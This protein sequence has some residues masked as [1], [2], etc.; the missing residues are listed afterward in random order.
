MQQSITWV[1]L[2]DIHYSLELKDL[3]ERVM[4]RLEV[5]LAKVLEQH[6]LRPDL[7]F[8]TGDLAH[9]KLDKHKGEQFADQFSRAG[10]LIERLKTKLSL[11]TDRIFVVPGNHDVDRGCVF[12]DHRNWLDEA[13]PDKIHRLIDRADGQWKHYASRLSTFRDFVTSHRLGHSSLDPDR[14]VAADTVDVGPTK[15]GIASFNTAWSCCRDSKDEKGQLWMG[16]EWQLAFAED[17]LK[18]CQLRIALLHHPSNWLREAEDHP[19]KRA[20]ERQ[21]HYV[22][23]GHEHNNWLERAQ[24]GATRISAAACF[25]PSTQDNGY[26]IARCV[27]DKRLELWFRRF[28]QAGDGFTSRPIHGLT[29]DSG[30]FDSEMHDRRPA[31]KV[32]VPRPTIAPAP[33][34]P[35][36]RD[37]SGAWSTT[38]A[39]D[40]PKGKRRR[41]ITDFIDLRLEDGGFFGENRD[42]VRHEY[43]VEGRVIAGN[44]FVGVWRSR[45][46]G[47]VYAGCFLMSIDVEGRIMKGRWLGIGES[48]S[49]LDGGR[50]EWQRTDDGKKPLRVIVKP[51]TKSITTG[52]GKAPARPRR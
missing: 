26:S 21:Y 20:L 30:Y 23:H 33:L 38:Y 24:H 37:L 5:D 32:V 42:N 40:N 44:W 43:R 25:D 7:L 12:E 13:T 51:A 19:L 18:A 45:K 15:I 3:R 9:G 29:D 31:P 39:F 4:A 2:S 50:W 22:L 1:H 10:A 16:H 34:A 27:P 35:E 48:A 49:E 28:D 46:L 8:L 41:K 11:H 52:L 47:V 14:L 36:Q 6:N 17:R